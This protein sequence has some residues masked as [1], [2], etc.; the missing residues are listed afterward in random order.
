MNCGIFS[1]HSKKSG[2][3]EG[4]KSPWDYSEDVSEGVDAGSAATLIWQQLKDQKP[5]TKK[6]ILEEIKSGYFEGH[7]DSS[8]RYKAEDEVAREYTEKTG[9]SIYDKDVDP[10]WKKKHDEAWQQGWAAYQ[11]DVDAAAEALLD[12]VW[13]RDFKGKK[14]FRF[15][16]S[17]NDGHVFSVLEHG[18]TFR[19]CKFIRISHH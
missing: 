16:F 8:D 13:E 5:L 19:N 4:V 11:K 9:K 12:R 6:Q 17:D 15:S 10:E 3:R 2:G 1:F 7:P 14:C 18:D